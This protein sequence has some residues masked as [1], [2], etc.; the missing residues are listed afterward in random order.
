MNNLVMSLVLVTNGLVVLGISYYLDGYL[1]RTKPRNLLGRE[2]LFARSLRDLFGDVAD[3]VMY[4]IYRSCVLIGFVG[5][6]F[7]TVLGVLGAVFLPPF[8]P[9]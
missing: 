5:G 6:L 4:Y 8:A 9:F 7:C 3:D 1:K 2:G